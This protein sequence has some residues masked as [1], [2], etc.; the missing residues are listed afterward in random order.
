MLIMLKILVG[1]Y[2][3][4]PIQV[5]ASFWFLICTFT[6]KAINV[7]TTPIFT[8]LMTTSEYGEYNVYTSWIGIFTVIISMNLSLGVFV[9]G[10]IKFPDRKNEFAS[11][12]QTLTFFLVLAWVIIYLPFKSQINILTGLNTTRTLLMIVTIWLTSVFGFWAAEQRVDYQYKKLVPVTLLVSVGGQVLGVTLVYF[13]KDKVTARILGTVIVDTLVYLWLFGL[14]LIR[15]R[16]LFDWGF[17]KYALLFNL[18]LV[19]HYLSQV[20]LNSSDRIMIDRMVDSSAAGIYGLAYSISQVMTMFNT[21]LAQTEEP[22]LYRKIGE[23]QIED[24]RPIAYFSFIFIAGVNLLLILFA[25]EIISFFA[26]KQYYAAIWVIPPIAMSVFFSFSYYFFAVFEYYFEK[27]KPIA[28]ASCIG[29]ILNIALNYL[30][31]P[32][33]GYTIAGYTTLFC[34]I[35]Y[36]IFHYIFMHQLCVE[37]LGGKEPFSIRIFI[38]ISTLF[39]VSGFGISL[40]YN[41]TPFVRY[42]LALVI[43][44]ILMIYKNKLIDLIKNIMSIRHTI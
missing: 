14:D 36:A 43:F 18:P 24:I 6:Q 40:T 16:R 33:Y 8:R 12:M 35:V 37:E 20:V 27:T 9:R 13:L 38:V 3:G 41:I 29:A 32:I 22:W 17:W 1:K 7:F 19:P 39:I 31:I 23:K 15:G 44:L 4:L 42:A 28:L 10:L 30:L 11:S 34:F 26:P 5:K 2:K 21:A 25:P